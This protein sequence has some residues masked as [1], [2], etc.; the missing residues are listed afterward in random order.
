M[1]D[2]SDSSEQGDSI[3]EYVVSKVSK[4][5]PGE[6]FEIVCLDGTFPL[7][8]AFARATRRAGARALIRMQDGEADSEPVGVR[9]SDPIVLPGR[10]GMTSEEWSELL[11]EP[12]AATSNAGRSRFFETL[13]RLVTGRRITITRPRTDQIEL[14]IGVEFRGGIDA[15]YFGR[16]NGSPRA[17]AVTGDPSVLSPMVA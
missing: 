17:A 4:I 12:G 10:L 16:P 8:G 6:T 15:F 2:A 14:A 3:A 9:K 1:S 7:A 11:S 5:R 13:E